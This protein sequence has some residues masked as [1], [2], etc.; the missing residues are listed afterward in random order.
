MYDEEWRVTLNPRAGKA[1]G[2]GEDCVK[3]KGMC[4]SES[5]VVV[6]HF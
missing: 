1:V 4:C 6:V 3:A 2:T 5:P